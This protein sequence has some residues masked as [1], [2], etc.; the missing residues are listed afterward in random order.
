MFDVNEIGLQG[1]ATR[2]HH[3]GW[4]VPALDA[5]SGVFGEVLGLPHLLDESLP[6]VE[7]RFF[8]AGECLVELLAPTASGGVEA[9]VARQGGGLHHL[10]FAVDDVDAALSACAREGCTLIDHSKRPGSRRTEIGF[11]DPAWPGGVLLEFVE[12]PS[13]S[14]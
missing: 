13:L 3:L 5:G 7:L 6:G 10:A 1:R 2:L 8:E 9:L 4:A 12:D 11:V 14:G